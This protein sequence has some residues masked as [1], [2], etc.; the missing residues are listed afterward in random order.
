[1][2]QCLKS[3]AESWLE[4]LTRTQDAKS[5]LWYKDTKKAYVAWEGHRGERDQSG[6]IFPSIV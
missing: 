4:A 3:G 1:M 6:L 5:K 2:S